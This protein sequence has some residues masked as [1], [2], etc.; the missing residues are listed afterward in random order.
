MNFDILQYASYNHVLALNEPEI[1]AFDGSTCAI[2][3]IAGN[4][5][6]AISEALTE[7]WTKLT[8]EVNE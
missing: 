8:G 7:E 4:M 1:I 6:E 3:V 5:Y 2:N